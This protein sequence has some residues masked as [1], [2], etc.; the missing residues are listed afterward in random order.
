MKGN[1]QAERKRGKRSTKRP[2]V[3]R[4]GRARRR[5]VGG[6]SGSGKREMGMLGGTAMHIK[7]DGLLKKGKK[8]F[9][10]CPAKKWISRRGI[11]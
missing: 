2:G 5:D 9:S 3:S 4:H 6:A 11:F 7:K 8:G 10:S 1:S